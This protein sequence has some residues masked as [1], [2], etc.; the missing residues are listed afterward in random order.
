[1]TI[2]SCMV[3][4]ILSVTDIIFCHFGLLFALLRTSNPENQ[5]FKKMKKKHPEIL[6]FYTSVPKIMII[7]YTVPE[8]WSVTDV[9][10]IFH[11]GQFFA[12][13]PP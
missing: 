11:S 1:M 12:L 9:V 4:E 2:I 7:G 5:N 8:T 10:F 13:L 6:S 3:P